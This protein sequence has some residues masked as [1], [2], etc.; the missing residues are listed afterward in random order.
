[1]GETERR[2]RGIVRL[3]PRHALGIDVETLVATGRAEKR[4]QGA[5]DRPVSAAKIEERV[6]GLQRR[7]RDENPVDEAFAEGDE[8]LDRRRAVVE[9]VDWRDQRLD[10]TAA[11]ESLDISAL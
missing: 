8:L 5:T 1:M 6:V 2:V 9:F 11:P 3:Q 7:T 4:R 10:S